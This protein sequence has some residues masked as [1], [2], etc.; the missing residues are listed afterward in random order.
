[1]SKP[2]RLPNCDA[3]ASLDQVQVRL[4]ERTELGVFQQLLDER[5]YLGSL[6]AVGRTPPLRGHRC[7]GSVTGFASLQRSSQAPQ[8]SRPMDRMERCSINNSRFLILAER[9]VPNLA[10]KVLR[11]TLDRLATHWQHSYGHPGLVVETFRRCCPVLR[12]GVFGQRLE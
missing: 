5:H 4:V 1:M 8:A 3:Q 7:P 2:L 6:K 12:Y 9:S 10:S 11:L